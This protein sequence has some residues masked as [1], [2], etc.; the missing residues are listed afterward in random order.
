MGEPSQALSLGNVHHLHSA[1]FDHPF[2]VC[3]SH[4]LALYWK[5]FGTIDLSQTFQSLGSGH[6]SLSYAAAAPATAITA[7]AATATTTEPSYIPQVPSVQNS[8]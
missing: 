4:H 6:H 1:P 3:P 7:A 5:D 2:C 8:L